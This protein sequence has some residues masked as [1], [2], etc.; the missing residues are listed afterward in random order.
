V[1]VRSH[2]ELAQALLCN[3][4]LVLDEDGMS[5]SADGV[6]EIL[7]CASGHVTTVEQGELPSPAMYASVYFL[8]CNEAGFEPLADGPAEH[9]GKER[10]P[11]VK[12]MHGFNEAPKPVSKPVAGGKK[13]GKEH[14]P[15]IGTMFG[16]VCTALLG[17]AAA[18]FALGQ[19]VDPDN[20]ESVQAYYKRVAAAG[21]K[22]L[23]RVLFAKVTM[24]VKVKQNGAEDYSIKIN[25][26]NM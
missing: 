6:K 4:K 19:G 17:D 20:D 5:A 14:P 7:K 2:S 12:G 22:A 24:E 15:Y 23:G 25:L 1:P 8:D 11:L 3:K 26:P 10:A 18:Y 13:E 9:L 21:D 16:D